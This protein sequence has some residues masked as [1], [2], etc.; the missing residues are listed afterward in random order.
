[1]RKSWFLAVLVL[2]ALV[3]GCATQGGKIAAYQSVD[4]QG[5]L[6]KADLARYQTE[7]GAVDKQSQPEAMPFLENTNWLI[8]GFLAY[9]DKG[10]VRVM[11]GPKGERTYM[12]SRTLGYGPLSVIWV[13]KEDAVYAGDGS[14]ASVMKMSSAFWGHLA[15]IHNMR[16]RLPDG[17][18][19][20]HSTSH[21]LHHILSIESGHG[22]G[23]VS[24]FSAP[25]PLGV[26][27]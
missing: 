11:T 17:S 14:L 21:L 15:M 20:N 12:V 9:W 8:P 24:L 26:D 19:H 2:A 18:W 16:S 27:Y 23:S 13:S 1:M 6:A 5:D 7:A 25:N 3:T 22:G 4:L 10:S